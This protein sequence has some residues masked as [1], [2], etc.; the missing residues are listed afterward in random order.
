M[1]LDAFLDAVATKTV[2]K[3]SAKAGRGIHASE[4]K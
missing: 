3:N 2:A 4:P 1:E